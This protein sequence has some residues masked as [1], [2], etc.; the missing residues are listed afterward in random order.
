MGQADDTL[1]IYEA[2]PE[3]DYDSCEKAIDHELE[4]IPIMET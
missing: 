4:M 1:T 2:L 3:Q